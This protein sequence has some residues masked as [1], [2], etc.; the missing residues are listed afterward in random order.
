MQQ[1]HD[2]TVIWL[3]LWWTCLRY[4]LSGHGV[5]QL[6]KMISNMD[7]FT[8]RGADGVTTVKSI[9]GFP[10]G[11][12]SGKENHV[13]GGGLTWAGSDPRPLCVHRHVEWRLSWIIWFRSSFVFLLHVPGH[14][15]PRGA[16]KSIN[17]AHTWHICGAIIAAGELC[18]CKILNTL[19]RFILVSHSVP[20]TPHFSLLKDILTSLVLS[21][22]KTFEVRQ[23]EDKMPFSESLPLGWAWSLLRR[24]RAA[25]GMGVVQ[26]HCK[27]V[28]PILSL[29]PVPWAQA[30]YTGTHTVSQL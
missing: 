17:S 7:P 22:G 27:A 24:R 9:W 25:C 28:D 10:L 18:L 20:Y 26:L 8:Q 11:L 21:G 13:G 4:L 1:V 30:G 14:T 12:Q 16:W 23:H 19:W 29:A 15:Y 3:F 2:S 6:G 5:W